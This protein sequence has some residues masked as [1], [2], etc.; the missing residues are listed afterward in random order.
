MKSAE[1]KVKKIVMSSLVVGGLMVVG[2][3]CQS[4]PSQPLLSPRGV[5]P[6]PYASPTTGLPTTAN[7]VTPSTGGETTE[8]PPPAP[9]KETI[10]PPPVPPVPPTPPPKET[11]TPP[12]PPAPPAE[13]TFFYTVKGGDSM[14]GIAYM[15]G[16]DAK[17]IASLNG[18]SN[19]NTIRVGQKLKVPG[20]G[21]VKHTIIRKAAPAGE[22]KGTGTG[23][24]GTGTIN[25]G[26]PV[27]A[28]GDYVIQSGDYPEKIAKR[29]GLKTSD[30]VAANPGVDPKKW[31][32]GQKVKIP[33]GSTGTAPIAGPGG[34]APEAIPGDKTPPPMPNT[35]SHTV[36]AGEMINDIAAL[37]NTTPQEI[38]D[39]NKTLKSEADIKEGMSIRVPAPRL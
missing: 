31:Q 27:P 9:P 1:N 16:V 21:K 32:I 23:G 36:L 29:F 11:I 25:K 13:S 33:A 19:L 39:L 15:Y 17:K 30:I 35:L 34:T 37:Y 22:S 28:D 12:A 5:I 6:K 20:D 7:S 26:E 2:V 10:T 3:G 38:L 8:I 18:I 4:T 24:S 14:S